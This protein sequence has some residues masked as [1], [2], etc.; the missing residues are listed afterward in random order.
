MSRETKELQAFEDLAN[1]EG[2]GASPREITPDLLVAEA[3]AVVR[4][5]SLHDDLGWYVR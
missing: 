3:R 5:T 2:E 1:V 4:R